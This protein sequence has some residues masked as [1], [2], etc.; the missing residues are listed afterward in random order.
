MPSKDLLLSSAHDQKRTLCRGTASDTSG[1]AQGASWVAKSACGMGRHY[2][3]GQER[4]DLLG[5]FREETRDPQGT[6]RTGTHATDRGHASTLL[7]AWLSA[8]VRSDP[9]RG[10]PRSSSFRRGSGVLLG[11]AFRALFFA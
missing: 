11:S 10:P 8:S 9:G 3:A 2:P 6:C 1:S 5:N 4:M 7:L